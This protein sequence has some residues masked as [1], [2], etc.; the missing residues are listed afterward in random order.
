MRVDLIDN[1]RAM[2]MMYVIF[3]HVLFWMKMVPLKGIVS[4]SV[5]LIEMP[6]FFI[7]TGMA[8]NFANT[9]DLKKYYISRLKRLLI[10]FWIF[11]FI[12]ACIS[13]IF[14]TKD[15]SVGK[16]FWEWLN[17]FGKISNRSRFYSASFMV[18]SCIFFD[19]A[20]YSAFEK[21]FSK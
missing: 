19:N 18:Y 12:C 20:F 11:A 17:P 2:A 13:I 21:T 9:D 5:F 1:F 4:N 15:I 3:I 6:L 7:V 10:P 16:V 14:A 8:H